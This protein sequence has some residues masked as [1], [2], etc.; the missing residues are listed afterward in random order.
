MLGSL[1]IGLDASSLVNTWPD[2]E[3]KKSLEAL[4]E[5]NG[6]EIGEVEGLADAIALRCV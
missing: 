5:Y 2:A 3:E 6:D 1:L 4:L